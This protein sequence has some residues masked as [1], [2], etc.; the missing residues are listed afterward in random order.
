MRSP[1]AKPWLVRLEAFQVRLRP[2][3][4]PLTLRDE[5]LAVLPEMVDERGEFR[6]RDLVVR[7]NPDNELRRR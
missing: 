3:P 6:L 4:Y 1:Q 5:V 7:L 2:G